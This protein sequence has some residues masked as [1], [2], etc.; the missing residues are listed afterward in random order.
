M[1][2]QLLPS[3]GPFQPE[4]GDNSGHIRPRTARRKG[5]ES[6]IVKQRLMNKMSR[7]TT[8]SK[9]ITLTFRSER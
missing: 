6:G 5:S 3:L 2:Y 7:L 8:A 9:S 4:T 1:S